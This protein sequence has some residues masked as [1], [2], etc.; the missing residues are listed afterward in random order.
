MQQAAASLQAATFLQKKFHKT[1]IMRLGWWRAELSENSLLFVGKSRNS[2]SNRRKK[3]AKQRTI[4]LKK[5]RLEFDLQKKCSILIVTQRKKRH[6]L[7]AYEGT[8]TK[9]A[10]IL[11]R[12][13]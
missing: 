10:H 3:L 1:D 5:R 12:R 9:Q 4:L 8:A 13:K 2:C 6:L 7:P 11:L